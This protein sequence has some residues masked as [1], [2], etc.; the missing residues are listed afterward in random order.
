MASSTR[1]WPRQLG[2]SGGAKQ[3]ARGVE[4]SRLQSLGFALLAELLAYGAYGKPAPKA[5]QQR[6]NSGS[7]GS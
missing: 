4:A 7:S 1:T 3:T 5:A 6:L 2:N